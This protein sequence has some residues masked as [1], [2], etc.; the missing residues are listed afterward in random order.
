MLCKALD[1]APAMKLLLDA[2]EALLQ[3]I[4]Q[5]MDS[6]T[7]SGDIAVVIAGTWNGIEVGLNQ[8]NLEGYV[9]GWRL[10]PTTRIRQI[11]SYHDHPIL[12]GPR[13][14]ERRLYV[15]EP[16][17]WGCCVRAKFEDNQDLRV[18][19]EPVSVERARELLVMNPGHFPDQP[20]EESKLRK[21]QA[22]VGLTIGTRVGFHVID[23]SRARQITGSS[24][25]S[26]DISLLRV[27]PGK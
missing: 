21:L 5:A 18:K 10:S 3:A 6:L 11:G 12:R 15:V 16:G 13:D 1:D 17:A 23:K 24:L 20:D 2:P 27:I 14:G 26:V 19:I 22:C 9:P 25:G 4:D 7:P 8:A